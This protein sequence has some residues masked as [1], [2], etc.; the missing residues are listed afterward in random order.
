MSKS[1]FK[2][3]LIHSTQAARLDKLDEQYGAQEK[4]DRAVVVV[5]DY[6]ENASLSDARK[7]ASGITDVVLG[8]A[9]SLAVSVFGDAAV[10]TYVRLQQRGRA[11]TRTEETRVWRR[12][13]P[14][15]D[16]ALGRWRL[17]HFHRSAPQNA[18][19]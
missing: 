5:S 11:T 9:S 1:N 6:V 10:V 17:V 8:G 19:G 15:A 3:P 4:L 12:C 2:A 7:A 13:A 18:Y 16:A 14:G